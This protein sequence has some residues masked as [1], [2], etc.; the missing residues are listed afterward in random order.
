MLI[1]ADRVRAIYDILRLEFPHHYTGMLEKSV[2]VFYRNLMFAIIK[3]LTTGSSVAVTIPTS[4]LSDKELRVLEEALT[5][6]GWQI[7]ERDRDYCLVV[8][9]KSY[10]SSEKSIM[11]GRLC[12]YCKIDTV[13]SFGYYECPQCHARVECHPGTTVAMGFVANR[14]LREKRDEVH[15]VLDSLWMEGKLKRNEVYARLREKMGLTKAQCH[16]A[17]FDEGQCDKSLKCLKQIAEE[18]K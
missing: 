12:P 16:V 8:P 7:K 1:K 3:Q 14:Q 15:H 17:K 18:L 4:L 2:L 13:Y 10:E 6:A 5:I 11:E 9:G